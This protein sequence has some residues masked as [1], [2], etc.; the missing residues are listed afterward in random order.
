MAP[1][2]DDTLQAGERLPSAQ[3]R[4]IAGGMLLSWPRE[5]EADFGATPSGP[6]R[7]TVTDA[8]VTSASAIH[9]VQSGAT[10]TGGFGDE[11]EFDPM[12]AVAAPG[13]GS[14]TLAVTPLAG[15]VVGKFKFLYV[16]G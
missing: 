6:K 14:F 5:Y 3:W 15:I 8:D 11:A 4:R 10:P 2:L 1:D 9:V 12:L 16:I 7:F 13:S